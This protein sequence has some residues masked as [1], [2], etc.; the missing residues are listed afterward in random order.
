MQT[1]LNTQ[2]FS[3]VKILTK[4]K[5]INAISP[6]A[7]QLKHRIIAKALKDKN[8]NLNTLE[9]KAYMDVTSFMDIILKSTE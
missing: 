5:R 2:S 3:V 1:Y 6:V 9:N 7:K 8:I 4:I